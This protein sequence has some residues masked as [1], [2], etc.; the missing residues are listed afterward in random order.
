MRDFSI[1]FTWGGGH[2]YN[3][4]LCFDGV[5]LSP[6]YEPV[7]YGVKS[8]REAQEIAQRGNEALKKWAPKLLH[9]EAELPGV[10]FQYPP[11]K[12][13]EATL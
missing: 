2:T 8:C 1:R 10:G 4:Y 6:I 3:V 7:L 11:S 12:E 9:K 13:S 5:S